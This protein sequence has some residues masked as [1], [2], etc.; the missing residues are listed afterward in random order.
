MDRR[1]FVRKQ[2]AQIHIPLGVLAAG[3]RLIVNGEDEQLVDE[4]TERRL[5]QLG[6]NREKP[7]QAVKYV[8]V[9]ELRRTGIEAVSVRTTKEAAVEDAE[10]EAKRLYDET[11]EQFGE[12]VPIERDED[13]WY[14]D[15]CETGTVYVL[16]AEEK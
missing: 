3:F 15:E 2:L 14:V 12:C 8:V 5:A 16:E 13:R 7:D 11:V 6:V 10:R 4:E 1:D 9:L